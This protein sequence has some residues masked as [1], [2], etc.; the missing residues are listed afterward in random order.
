MPAWR[1]SFKPARVA[2]LDARLLFILLPTL[3]WIRW[4]TVIPLI[5]VALVLYYVERRLEMSVPSALRAVRSLIAGRI[6]PA[7]SA[8]KLRRAVDFDRVN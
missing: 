8:D 3:L 6:R 7:R 4:Y 2:V 1:D 5:V